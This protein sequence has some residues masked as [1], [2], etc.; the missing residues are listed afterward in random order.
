[1][2]HSKSLLS[3]VC[4][5]FALLGPAQS[6]IADVT[7]QLPATTVTQ[8]Q[9]FQ[10]TFESTGS[11]ASPPDL[12]ALERDFQIVNRSV[13]QQTSVRNGYRTQRMALTLTLV[14]LHSG[15]VE[16]PAVQFGRESSRPQTLTVRAG[17]GDS[18]MTGV[19]QQNWPLP[20]GTWDR[21][22]GDPFSGQGPQFGMPMTEPLIPGY[23]AP[24]T[25]GSPF[26]Q[27]TPFGQGSPFDQSIPFN[28]GT[29]FSQAD[30]PFGSLSPYTAS[31]PSPGEVVPPYAEDPVEPPASPVHQEDGYPG[32][33]VAVLAG[34]W[35]ATLVVLGIR[36]LRPVNLPVM[37][38]PAPASHPDLPPAKPPSPQQMAIA[39]VE[40]AYDQGDPKAAREALLQ[41]SRTLWAVDAPLTLTG[42]AERL[43]E[44]LHSHVMTLDKALY[45][46]TP[47]RWND[48]AIASL[49]D[50]CK[51]L[52]EHKPALS[53]P[54]IRSSFWA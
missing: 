45:S 43:Q 12:T 10:I 54:K 24:F 26:D 5:A 42:L 41:W 8:G 48:V 36:Q 39:A 9:P 28:Q 40:K 14:P 4:L 35:L 44:P 25:Q 53:G 50:N 49:L 32:W 30:P 51:P 17:S 23:G 46:P 7:V 19:P 6:A 13:R 22:A 37:T 15:K 21:F 18:T 27:A 2:N 33:L 3:R 11:V 20:Q 16:I 1:M 29:P 31:P 38:P 34:G 47:L 52:D